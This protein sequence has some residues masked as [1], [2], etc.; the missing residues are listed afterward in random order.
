MVPGQ[1]G[2]APPQSQDSFASLASE[3]HEAP[4]RTRTD[5]TTDAQ[6]V[7]TVEGQL[8]D[9]RVSHQELTHEVQELKGENWLLNEAFHMNCGMVTGKQTQQ[10]N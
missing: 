2:A 5:K 4:P 7:A 9:L 1:G 3:K 8:V 6:R 10:R